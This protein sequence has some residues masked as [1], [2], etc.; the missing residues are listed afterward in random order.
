MSDL[1]GQSNGRPRPPA[2]APRPWTAKASGDDVVITTSDGSVLMLVRDD[3]GRLP[4]KEEAAYLGSQHVR[5]A[6]RRVCV[7]VV[8]KEKDEVTKQLEAEIAEL[9][10]ENDR[11]RE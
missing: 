1:N 10:A 4:T 8:R 6:V 5:D 7:G 9:K 2:P 3:V 11:L